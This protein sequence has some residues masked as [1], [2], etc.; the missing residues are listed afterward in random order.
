MWRE[1]WKWRWPKIGGVITAS[2]IGEGH[3]HF[4]RGIPGKGSGA[5]VWVR[6]FSLRLSTMAKRAGSCRGLPHSSNRG[7]KLQKGGIGWTKDATIELDH[8]K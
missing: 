7:A 1:L 2:A 6:C 5:V 8:E 3:D 4:F